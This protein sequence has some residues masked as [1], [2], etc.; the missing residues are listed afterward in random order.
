MD[1]TILV[2]DDEENLLVLLE[3]ILSREGFSVRTSSNAYQALDLVDKNTFAVAI[4]DIKMFP[5]D[6]VALLAEI[7]KRSPST[8]V[9]MITAYPTIDT[10]NECLKIGASTY[11]TKPLDIHELKSV[12]QNL[13]SA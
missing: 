13:A 2:V 12:V 3:R 9:V 10:R 8:H 5:V 7:K 6:G 4:L 1:R 11:L